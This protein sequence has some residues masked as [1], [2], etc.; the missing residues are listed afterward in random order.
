LWIENGSWPSVVYRRERRA[1][2][3][4][5]VAE[6]VIAGEQAVGPAVSLGVEL[7]SERVQLVVDRI[8]RVLERQAALVGA[9]AGVVEADRERVRRNRAHRVE[10][11]VPERELVPLVHVPVELG[12]ELVAVR[13]V[14]VVL[15]GPRIVI[16]DVD[17]P[18]ADRFE[19]GRRDA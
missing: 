12:D 18:L 1:V 11:V 6:P 19:I 9:A 8:A 13:V 2:R 3:L 4:A 17:H 14:Y 5:E 10:Q 16:V 15:E 7:P